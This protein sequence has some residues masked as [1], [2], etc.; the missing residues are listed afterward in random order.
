MYL[1]SVNITLYLRES[2]CV[3]IHVFMLH[4]QI[5]ERQLECDKVFV[6]KSGSLFYKTSEKVGACLTYVNICQ[7]CTH[8]EI[9][10]SS[11]NCVKNVSMCSDCVNKRNLYASL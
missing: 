5:L 6:V 8:L 4:D 9:L 11:D 3:C 2:S 1:R 7:C 10:I